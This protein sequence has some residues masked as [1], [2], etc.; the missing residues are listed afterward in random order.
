MDVEGDDG[1]AGE[2]SGIG[3]GWENVLDRS[4]TVICYVVAGVRIVCQK[5]RV[6]P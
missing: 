6:V 3:G 5:Y 1:D 2:R 4:G